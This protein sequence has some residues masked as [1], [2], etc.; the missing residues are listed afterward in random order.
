MGES[1]HDWS[2]HNGVEVE[3]RG[4]GRVYIASIY[5]DGMQAED[6]YQAA[7]YTRGGPLWQVRVPPLYARKDVATVAIHPSAPT[8]NSHPTSVWCHGRP[9]EQK[10]QI[11]FVDFLLTSYGYVQNEQSEFNARSI[12]TFGVLLADQIDG[13]F[14]LDIRAIRAITMKK[15]V[16]NHEAE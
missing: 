2:D 3:L 14:K 15:L 6:I 1:Y 8:S 9:P 5:T 12:R 13:E 7:I 10:V 16:T 4:D 11:P